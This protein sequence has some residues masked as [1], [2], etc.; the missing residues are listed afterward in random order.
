MNEKKNIVIKP[1]AGLCNRLRFMFSYIKRLQDNSEFD[2]TI[3]HLF[4]NSAK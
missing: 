1:L 3:K 2:N 4:L